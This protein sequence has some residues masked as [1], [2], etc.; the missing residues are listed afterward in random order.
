MATFGNAQGYECEFIEPVSDDYYCKKCTLVARKLTFTSCCG[1]GYCQ[2]CIT[3]IQQQANPCPACG[4]NNFT[5]TASLKYQQ[6]MAGLQ[7][8]CSMKGRGCGWAGILEQ[9]DVHLDPDLDNCQ[10]MNISCPLNY[11]KTVCK[12]M[13]EQHVAEEYDQRDYGSQHCATKSNYKVNVN[14]Q[15][16][17][18]P[19]LSGVTCEHGLMEDNTSMCHLEEVACMVTSVV[20]EGK[21][22]REEL[23]EQDRHNTQKHLTSIAAAAVKM[24]EQLQHQKEKMQQQEKKNQTQEEKILILEQNINE[25]EEFN[26]LLRDKSHQNE[27]DLKKVINIILKR[28]FTMENFSKEKATASSWE[29]PTM[30]TNLCG[31]KFCIGINANGCVDGNGHGIGVC[32]YAM[33]GEYDHQLKWPVRVT[34]TL[35]LIHQ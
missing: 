25:L 10:Y 24:K 14:T 32:L 35:E 23:E 2:A 19:N 29:S 13:V 28:T 31:Y 6:I 16:P 21:S 1:E 12:N 18:C 7:V 33:L 15:W 27:E 3:D 22:R 30:Y 5:T 8:Y 34:F 4:Q 9:L 17:E 20:Y 11:R 26:K